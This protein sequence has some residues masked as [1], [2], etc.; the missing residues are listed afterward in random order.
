[1]FSDLVRSKALSA[2]MDP[3]DVSEVISACQA[4]VLA[5]S[6][7]ALAMFAIRGNDSER[8]AGT[9]SAMVE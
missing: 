7:G 1:M 6:Q 5:R 2:C 9:W 8:Q 3:E 4:P